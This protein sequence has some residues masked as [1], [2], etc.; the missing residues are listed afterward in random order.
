MSSNDHSN[1]PYRP[2]VGIAMF[3][4]Y[5]DVFVGERIDSPGAWQMPQGGI[6]DGEDIL[7]AAKREL[8]EEVGTDKVELIKIADETVCYDVPIEL[9][10][11]HWGGKFRGQEQTWVAMRFI[12]EDRDIKLDQHEV[13]EFLRWQWVPLDRTVDLI[14]PFKRETYSKVISFFSD[15]FN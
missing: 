8:M 14:V 10:T 7:V 4:A 11:K 3:N 6:D 13:P 5:G 15:L 1:L 12:G 9:S 2:C